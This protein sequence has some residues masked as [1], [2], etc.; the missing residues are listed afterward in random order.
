MRT[1]KLTLEYDGTGFAGWAAQ[2]GVRTVEQTLRDA[3]EAVFP[4]WDG[5]EVAGRTDAGVHALGQVAS[6]RVQGGPPLERAAEALDA[7]LPDDVSVVGAEPA[8][9]GFHARFSPRSRTYRYRIWRRR[10]PSPFE[11]RRSWWLPRPLD[12]ARPRHVRGRGRQVR[13]TSGRSR[14]PRPSMRCSF[15][16][17][18]SAAGSGT[19]TSSRSTSRP[20]ASSGTWCGRSSGPCSTRSPAELARLLEGRPRSEA[21]PT[22]PPWGL[23][24]VSVAYDEPPGP[25]GSA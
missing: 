3:L 11:S 18:R 14:R 23:Y 6:V 24:L 10:T 19:E 8:P 4:R 12:E 1:L 5:L 13:T 20:T 17:S 25:G 9:E 2:P 22:A 16:S 7:R 21:G 15:A